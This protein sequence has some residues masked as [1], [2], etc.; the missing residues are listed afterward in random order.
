MKNSFIRKLSFLFSVMVM[1]A[2]VSFTSSTY[3]ATIGQNL[4][5]P[6][7][8][9]QRVDANHNF[10]AQTGAWNTNNYSSA[11][12]QTLLHT[13]E[14]GAKL[15]FSF[16]GTK[17]RIL[18]SKHTNRS[19][20]IKVTIDGEKTETF[21]EFATVSSGLPTLVYEK[22]GLPEGIHSIVI[23]VDDNKVMGFDA[24][25]LDSEGYLVDASANAPSNLSALFNKGKIDLTW[26]EINNATSYNI[27]RSTTTG[28]PY[29]R[30]ADN[31][32]GT[33]FSDENGTQGATYYYVVTAMNKDY[34]SGR[35]NEASV[36]LEGII[37]EPEQPSGNRAILV[38]TMTTGLEKEFDLNMQEVNNFIDWYEAKQAGDGRASYAID[39]HDNNKGPF[40]SR[41]DY[42][43]FDR[44]LTFEVSEY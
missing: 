35:S 6:E 7:S 44:V 28:G 12:A 16:Y 13:N 26:T 31:I 14:K 17:F 36:T 33:L 32:A 42:I 18:D 4:T 5:A 38:V 8:G 19:S 1:I 34:E 37:I 3:A 43:L 23:T 20:S 39:K 30:I 10:I 9:W 40:K 15:H 21:S 25:D 27:Y 29:E 11:W 2:V 22:V 41:K 24:F